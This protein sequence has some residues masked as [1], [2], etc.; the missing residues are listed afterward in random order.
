MVLAIEQQHSQC[1]CCQQQ[2][3]HDCWIDMPTKMAGIILDSDQI[4]RGISKSFVRLPD[5]DQA[6]F[7]ARVSHL[8]HQDQNIRQIGNLSSVR[9]LTVLYLYDNRYDK[10][11]MRNP[12]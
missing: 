7:L 8:H 2:P 6:H 1:C 5:E 10:Q 12:S 11:S 9:N 3:L 4:N